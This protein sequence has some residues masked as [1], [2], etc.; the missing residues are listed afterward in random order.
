MAIQ[1]DCQFADNCALFAST[2][3]GVCHAL[4]TFMAISSS[5]GLKVN[6]GKTKIMAVGVYVFLENPCPFRVYSGEIEHVSKFRYL[7]LIINA[8][9]CC[10]RDIKSRISSVSRAMGV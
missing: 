6:L 9:G 10:H 2:H 8:D 5:F 1:T 4:T 3:G 7:G